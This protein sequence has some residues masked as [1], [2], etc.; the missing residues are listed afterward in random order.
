MLKF[1]VENII[2]KESL[3]ILTQ[4]QIDKLKLDTR[5]FRIISVSQ[6]NRELGIVPSCILTVFKKVKN[7]EEFDIK[8]GEDCYKSLFFPVFTPTD[9]D[10]I[11]LTSSGHYILKES[12]TPSQK[13]WMEAENTFKNMIG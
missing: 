1:Y 12:L 13:I 11:Y 4:N 5:V 7:G 6:R 8:S 10:K 9:L 2:T 3:G